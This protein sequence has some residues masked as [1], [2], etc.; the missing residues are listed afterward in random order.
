MK[1]RED[2]SGVTENDTDKLRF[3]FKGPIY[4]GKEAYDECPFHNPRSLFHPNSITDGR[5]T[6]LK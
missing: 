1:V 2:G 6:L 4:N 5:E 3:E